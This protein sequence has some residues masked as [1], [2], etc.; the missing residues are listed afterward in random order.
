MGGEYHKLNSFFQRIG[1][2]H[3]VS[4]PYAHQQNGS[5]ERKHHH[6]VEVGLSLLAYAQMP[7]K[8]WDEA[9]LTGTYLIN[10]LPTPVLQGSTPLEMLFHIKPDYTSLRTFGCACW[11]NLRPYNSHKLQFRLKRCVFLGYS[12]MHKGFKC[13]DVTSGR[14]YISRDVVFDEHIY[15]FSDLHPNAGHCLRAEILLLPEHLLNPSRDEHV[16]QSVINSSTNPAH[17]SPVDVATSADAAAEISGRT[18]QILEQNTH[19]FLLGGRP[20]HSAA[21]NT[22]AAPDDAATSDA[23]AAYHPGDIG[24]AAGSSLSRSPSTS[25]SSSRVSDSAPEPASP[26]RGDDSLA[27]PIDG[28]SSEPLSDSS[29]SRS[30][31]ATNST[32]NNS[33]TSSEAALTQPQR[34]ATRLQQGIR[35]PKVYTYGTVR[36][37]NLITAESEPDTLNDALNSKNWKLAMDSEFLALQKNKTWHLVPPTKGKNIID[38]KWVYKIKKKADRTIDRYKARLLLKVLNRDMKLT[39]RTPSVL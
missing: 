39:M 22:H 37:A 24:A 28:G 14:V 32:A 6:I 18:G 8:F 1:I 2:S 13:L 5:A 11:P 16:D 3:R 21:P 20:G 4:C 12:V 17:E 36:W 33:T 9:F 27:V 10:R 26:P 34:P 35:K 29:S 7:L 31:T 38:Y 23:T 19:G 25:H 15:P 30:S